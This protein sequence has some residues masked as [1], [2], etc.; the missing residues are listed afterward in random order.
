MRLVM[1]NLLSYR[2]QSQNF[3]FSC[4]APTRFSIEL[5]ILSLPLRYLR[6]NLEKSPTATAVRPFKNLANSNTMKSCKLQLMTSQLF[7]FS[8]LFAMKRKN[9]IFSYIL[10]LFSKIGTSLIAPLFLKGSDK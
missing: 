10:L 7:Y 9:V 5:S 6:P 4:S 1:W 2:A 8:L 3:S